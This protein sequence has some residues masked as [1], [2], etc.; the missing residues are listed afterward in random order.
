MKRKIYIRDLDWTLEPIDKL[1]KEEQAFHDLMM[2][3][4]VIV[5]DPSEIAKILGT[6]FEVQPSQTAQIKKTLQSSYL[7]SKKLKTH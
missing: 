5:D 2:H 7:T 4:G 6:E 3:E 1:T